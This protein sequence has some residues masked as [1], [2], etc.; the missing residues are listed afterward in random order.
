M[1]ALKLTLAAA[2]KQEN[3]SFKIQYFKDCSN[4]QFKGVKR[5]S[6]RRSP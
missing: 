2:E 4:R 3:K 5:L 6:R 1:S